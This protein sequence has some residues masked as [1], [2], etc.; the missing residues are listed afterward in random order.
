MKLITKGLKARDQE[1][2]IQPLN[3]L[4]GA[5]GS[6]KSTT[7]DGLRFLALGYVPTLGKRPADTAALM[8][9]QEMSVSLQ[10]KD[11][12]AIERSLAKEGKALVGNA[13][14]SWNQSN[15]TSEHAKAITALFGVE[16][17][18]AAELMDIRSL[19][20]ATPA[21]RAARVE[22]LVTAGA[23]SPDA[24]ATAI[25]ALTVMRLAD[26]TAARMPENYLDALALVPEGQQKILKLVAAQLMT[27]VQEKGIEGTLNWAN[28]EK[29]EAATGLVR[30][31]QAAKEIRAKL[32][33]IP[34][35][36]HESL[37]KMTTEVGALQRE[38]GEKK[39]AL[40]H[41][42]GN[43]RRL[44]HAKK[45]VD[46]QTE[47]EASCRAAQKE[48]KPLLEDILKRSQLSVDDL[49]KKLTSLKQPIRE[50]VDQDFI[51]QMEK[52]REKRR[53]LSKGLNTKVPNT[54][55]AGVKVEGIKSQLKAIEDSDWKAVLDVAAAMK[56]AKLTGKNKDLVDGWR[57]KLE[58]TAKKGLGN[59]PE[60]LQK[61]LAPA[62]EALKKA[63]EEAKAW[64]DEQNAIGVKVEK[65]NASIQEL[66]QEA[67]R[68]DAAATEK[69]DQAMKLYN[70]STSA[71]RH[72]VAGEAQ[73]ILQTK[74]Q[75]KL[76]DQALTTAEQEFLRA[77]N[78]VDAL[79]FP[80]EKPQIPDE[81]S[82]DA[83]AKELRGLVMAA[84]VYGQLNG[85]L[86]QIEA[87]KAERDVFAAI[88]WGAQRQREEE[89]SKSEG[90]V[91]K[92]TREFLE[93]AG[94]TEV[95]FVRASAGACIVGWKAGEKEVP[96]QS[97]SGG[98]WA[99]FTAALTAA[100]MILR[101]P[102]IRI[103]IVEAGETDAKVLSQIAAGCKAVA[104]RLTGVVVMSPRK[105]QFESEE[106]GWNVVQVGDPVIVLEG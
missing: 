89:L 80:G 94:R 65:L 35:P 55:D 90:G 39:K 84:G 25:A 34:E 50:A 53:E 18:D 95:P 3:I 42:E 77:A 105:F 102:E 49:H 69:Y 92:I 56:R 45:E 17:L 72:E 100:T 4:V 78:A 48:G 29:R 33:D 20:N 81:A 28:A 101:G 12:K 68:R 32:Q 74:E 36:N 91:L 37:D 106:H 66:D 14:C 75:M 15:K 40:E 104:D 22:Q 70:D 41:W 54:Y 7:G 43:C 79:P 62:E 5:N 38:I 51:G 83:K 57:A 64:A 87:E 73:K 61:E 1:L 96:V 24:R 97:L 93:A 58:A 44:E 13:A 46:A 16:D 30:K 2:E 10:F 26:T 71:H 60:T 52:H 103:L 19:L 59:D 47:A 99:V 31:E 9:G 88:E 67:R 8:S 85:I 76:L 21:A 6:G 27:T 82:V 63:T 86:V 98:E 11:G 23:L